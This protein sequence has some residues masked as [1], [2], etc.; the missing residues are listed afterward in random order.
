M[1]CSTTFLTVDGAMSDP[2]VWFPPFASDESFALLAEQMD[3]AGAMLVGR[4]TY[5]ELAAW[6]PHQP[7][8]VPLATRTNAMTKYVVSSTLRRADWSGSE[9]LPAGDLAGAVAG[10]EA[11]HGTVAVVGSA[12]LQ[13]SLLQ[14]GLLDELRLYLAPV[15]L[16][17]G[18][19]L[20]DGAVGPTELRIADRR[21]LPHGV[22]YLAYRI[23]VAPD[24][25]VGDAGAAHG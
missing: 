8:S 23:G 4:R 10:L 2:H 7:D 17:E 3:A 25:A 1:L 24:A 16:G 19:R 21:P 6:W 18:T 5:E 20:F 22:Q 13:R 14:S 9:I 11:R 15:V 12:T